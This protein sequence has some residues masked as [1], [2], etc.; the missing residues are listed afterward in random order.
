LTE[1]LGIDTPVTLTSA[2]LQRL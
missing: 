2:S 1:N